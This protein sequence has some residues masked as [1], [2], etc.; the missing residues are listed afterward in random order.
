MT[1]A[2]V[3]CNPE[4]RPIFEPLYAIDARTSATIEVF[5]VRCPACPVV[6]QER[7]RLVSL[8]CQP[9]RLPECPPNGYKLAPWL[10]RPRMDRFQLR[11]PEIHVRGL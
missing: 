5:A 6:R 8:S 1:R 3:T 9:G 2:I 11:R 4:R 7:C 10:G